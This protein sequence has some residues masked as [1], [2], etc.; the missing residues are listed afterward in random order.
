ML[1]VFITVGVR[2]LVSA[3]ALHKCRR[4]AVGQGLRWGK[5]VACAAYSAQDLPPSQRFR[6]LDGL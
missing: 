5:T 6:L 3:I 2:K 1:L 4:Q